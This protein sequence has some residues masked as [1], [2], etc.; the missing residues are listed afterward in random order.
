MNWTVCVIYGYSNKET[1]FLILDGLSWWYTTVNPGLSIPDK[2]LKISHMFNA[3]G[4]SLYLN[5]I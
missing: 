1:L 5:F 3:F 2:I 4:F